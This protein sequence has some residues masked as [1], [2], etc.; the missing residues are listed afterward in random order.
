MTVQGDGTY[1]VAGA[2]ADISTS[3]WSRNHS[4]R[5][6]G[7]TPSVDTEA[8]LTSCACFHRRNPHQMPPIR[9]CQRDGASPMPTSP[10]LRLPLIGTHRVIAKRT[11]TGYL[12]VRRPYFV[13]SNMSLRLN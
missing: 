11:E 9:Y 4:R 8:C 1:L 13:C 5:A 10:G 7:S 6:E 3:G 2:A 12:S